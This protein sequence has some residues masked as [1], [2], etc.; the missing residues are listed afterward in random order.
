MRM[1]Y[2]VNIDVGLKEVFFSDLYFV[3]EP[4][5]FL[6]YSSPRLTVMTR[7]QQS[8][9]REEQ[10]NWFPADTVDFYPQKASLML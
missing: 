9:S 6:T 4:W 5:L 1:Y 2:K 3:L 8:H 7:M 10:E